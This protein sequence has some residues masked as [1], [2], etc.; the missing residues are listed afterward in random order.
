[1]PKLTDKVAVITGGGSGVGKAVAALFLRE[2]ATVVIAGRDPQKLAAAGQEL[3][4]GA[5]AATGGGRAVGLLG[6]PTDVGKADQCRALI[7][8]A[9]RA[10]GRVDILVN[11][12]GTNIKE[13]TIRELTPEAWDMMVGANLNG[14]FY[15]TKAVLPQM[16]DRKDGVIVN[17]VSVAGKRANPLGGAAYVAAKF[18][19]GGLGVALSNEEKDSGV[20]VSNIYPGEI[21]TPILVA[22]PKPVTDEQRALILKPEDVAEAVLFVATLPPRVSVPELVI[23][24][25]SQFYW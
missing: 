9:T 7:D 25:T 11:N 18:G 13:R 3:M 1:M 22:R 19:M 17:V 2:G 6:V 8:E 15:C 5:I 23:K 21:D 14:A 24:P 20:R 4:A 12:A 10:Y 16:L